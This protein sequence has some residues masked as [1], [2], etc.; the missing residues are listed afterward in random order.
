MIFFQWILPVPFLSQQ[1]LNAN[2]KIQVSQSDGDT[3]YKFKGK[4]SIKSRKDLM[5]MLDKNDQRGLGGTLL[6]DV[7]ESLPQCEKH[8]KVWRVYKGE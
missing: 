4:L 2:P 7:E 8:L 3:M 5:K 1:A 6:E